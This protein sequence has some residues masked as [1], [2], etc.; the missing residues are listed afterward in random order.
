[1]ARV[2]I[3]TVATVAVLALFSSKPTVSGQV[4]PTRNA[5]EQ[6][7]PAQASEADRRFAE[8]T[9]ARR[10]SEQI[11]LVPQMEQ[12]I[13]DYPDYPRIDRVYSTLLLALSR[14]KSDPERLEALAE[15]ALARFTGDQS[16]RWTAYFV[17]FSL[18]QP[19][20]D[21]FKALSL[22]ILK[23]ETNPFLLQGAAS[24]DKADALPLLEK[25]IAERP[26]HPDTLT[27]PDLDELQWSYARSLA[28]A[29]RTDEA[30]KWS[31]DVI[32]GTNRAIAELESSRNN[33]DEKRLAG[34]YSVDAQLDP[35]RERLGDRC[36][37]FIPL[38]LK[39]G[40]SN[41]ALKYVAMQERAAIPILDRRPELLAS[42]AQMYEKLGRTDLAMDGLVR[43]LAARLDGAT[44]DAIAALAARTGRDADALY[45]RA[46]AMRSK[47]ATPAYPFALVTDD[48]KPMRLSDL[49]GRVV[50]VSFFFPT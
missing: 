46:A 23:T 36:A 21:D 6:T 4:A 44:R 17:K 14:A 13:R 2:V 9:T 16:V 10:Q 43:A 11:K 12:F 31:M 28:D 22:Q 49:K 1:M 34:A 29:G 32:A 30:L 8:I 42:A 25:A 35:L 40:R 24:V 33:P 37:E 26:K 27:M 38:L 20:S 47:S 45:R 18:L 41:L 3:S 5:I 15:E 39:G 50:L 7:P 48:G 19:G